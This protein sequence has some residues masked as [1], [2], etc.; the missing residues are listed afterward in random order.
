MSATHDKT[1]NLSEMGCAIYRD[2]LDRLERA[3]AGLTPGGPDP[4]GGSS[5]AIMMTYMMTVANERHGMDGVVALMQ[6]SIACAAALQTQ[7]EAQP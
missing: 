5:E 1:G 2:A 6:Q 4:K 3:M 7:M